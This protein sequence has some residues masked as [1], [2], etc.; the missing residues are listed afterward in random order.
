[1]QTFRIIALLLLI[2][3]SAL[4]QNM[5][6]PIHGSLTDSSIYVWIQDKTSDDANLRLR[7]VKG[8]NLVKKEQFGHGIYK[9]HIK[10]ITPNTKIHYQIETRDTVIYRT[11]TT[12]KKEQTSTYNKFSFTY[13]SCFY[14][15]DFRY[16]NPDYPYGQSLDI[17]KAIKKHQGD[18][19][20]WG[21]DNIY[22]KVPDLDNL[23][24]MLNR[25]YHSKSKPEINEF[26]SQG[27]HYF[28]WDDHDFGPNNSNSEFEE[29]RNALT[30]FKANSTNPSYGLDSVLGNFYS[31]QRN[32][33][34]FIALDNRF[35]RTADTLNHSVYLGQLQYTWL[36]E[37]LKNSTADFNIILGGSQFM[38]TK[39]LPEAMCLS[40]EWDSLKTFIT[41]EKING[42]LFISGD[43]HFSEVL[44]SKNP[45]SYNLIE[46]TSSPVSSRAFDL[47]SMDQFKEELENP[48]RIEGSRIV[49][50]NFLEIKFKKLFGKKVVGIYRDENGKVLFSYKV[51]LKDINN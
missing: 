36:C 35:H 46:F 15:N 26:L 27:E 11:F 1:M 43:R 37:E 5:I 51:K 20:I 45:G 44:T 7:F 24:S 33:V 23:D 41:E 18:F 42:V 30:A 22:F 39:T 19:F 47:A 31:F 12:L 10:K 4:T 38:N 8:I 29:K 50:N 3:L 17:F 48:M 2:S 16:D 14:V 40:S 21:G 13:G 6:G 49:K 34:K 28:L 9:F 32:N 25:Y